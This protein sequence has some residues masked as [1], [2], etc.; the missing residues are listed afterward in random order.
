MTATTHHI[1]EKLDRGN[2][3]AL[4]LPIFVWGTDGADPNDPQA[5]ITLDEAIAEINAAIDIPATLLDL[6]NDGDPGV[7]QTGLAWRITINYR[8][9]GLRPLHPPGVGEHRAGFNFHCRRKWVNLATQVAKFPSGSG[10]PDSFDVPNQ[11]QDADGRFTGASGF[12]L[13]PPGADLTDTFSVDPADVTHSYVRG[14]A[15]IIA[16]GMVNSTSLVS[17]SYAA[18]ELLIAYM[19][20]IRMSDHEFLIDAGWSWQQNVTG[21]TRGG[22]TGVHYDGQDYVWDWKEPIVD[23]STNHFGLNPK[24]TYVH[25]VRPR[26]DIS[27]VGFVPP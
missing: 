8:E 18:G 1:I 11:Q 5:P 15:A 17:G 12:W 16:A 14:I 24:Y 21:E 2:S 13:E 20:G 9:P 3:T 7:E 26:G 10:T 4:A 22:V 27:A 19:V 23:R 25:R 6:P